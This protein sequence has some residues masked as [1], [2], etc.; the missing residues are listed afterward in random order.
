MFISVCFDFQGFFFLTEWEL[1]RQEDIERD[2]DSE[3]GKNKK[4]G[5]KGGG[6]DV[7]NWG[8]VKNMIKICCIKIC[9]SNNN[10]KNDNMFPLTPLFLAGGVIHQFFLNVLT[11]Q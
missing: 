1:G 5:G 2:R 3:K 7:R 4:L 6:E 11:E 10:K 9:L 8:R